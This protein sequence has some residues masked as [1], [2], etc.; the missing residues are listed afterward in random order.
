MVDATAERKDLQVDA[1]D[2]PNDPT[3]A[4][5]HITRHAKPLVDEVRGVP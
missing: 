4:I 5:G 1:V 2:P 3:T